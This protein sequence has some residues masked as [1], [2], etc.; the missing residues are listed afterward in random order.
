MVNFNSPIP[1]SI[2][3][4]QNVR[5]VQFGIFLSL[6]E[7]KPISVMHALIDCPELVEAGKWKDR[8]LMDL[9]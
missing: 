4:Y 6:D 8:G 2:A 5:H 1:H 9:R 7:I 3:P